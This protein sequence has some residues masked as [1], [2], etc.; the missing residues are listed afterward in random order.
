MTRLLRRI[1]YVPASDLQEAL[2]TQRVHDAAHAAEKKQLEEHI[3]SLRQLQLARDNRDTGV[4]KAI[5]RLDAVTTKVIEM[6]RET[7][8]A[9]DRMLDD[10]LGV[11][12]ST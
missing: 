1:G 6:A 10:V 9:A 4:Q 11:P 7:W 8:P 12:A 2:T 5:D 3:A